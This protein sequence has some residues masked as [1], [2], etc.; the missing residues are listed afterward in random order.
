MPMHDNRI[1]ERL[2]PKRKFWVGMMNGCLIV[3]AIAV[4]IWLL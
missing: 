1:P 4:L 2:A 3:G